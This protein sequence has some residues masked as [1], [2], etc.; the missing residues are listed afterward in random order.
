MDAYSIAQISQTDEQTLL[1]QAVE[2]IRTVAEEH[3]VDLEHIYLFGSRARGEA[4]SQSD[5]DFYVVI[6]QE[7]TFPQRRQIASRVR[8]LL[9]QQGV[10]GDVFV[11]GKE[12]VAR[13]SSDT[14]CLTYYALR[15]GISIYERRDS[16]ELDTEGR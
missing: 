9:A 15:E 2:V 14:G 10:F 5:W 7:L 16:E 6:G 3:G 12:T 13:R 11:Q 1:Q 8:R 4:D